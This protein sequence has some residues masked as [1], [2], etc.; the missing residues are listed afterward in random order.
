MRRYRLESADT[1]QQR[2]S[3]R[4]YRLESAG[5][6]P[7]TNP[8]TTVGYSK[9]RF[10]DITKS[11]SSLSPRRGNSI[12]SSPR[13]ERR[14]LYVVFIKLASTCDGLPDES[15]RMYRQVSDGKPLT[16]GHI[17]SAPFP[18]HF[19]RRGKRSPSK[20]LHANTL[21]ES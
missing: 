14:V 20:S 9:R 18:S 2:R 21:T 4:S 1:N 19:L 8:R 5:R 16:P 12:S 15:N 3:I 17:P 7:R 11:I 13:A 6:S 10:T